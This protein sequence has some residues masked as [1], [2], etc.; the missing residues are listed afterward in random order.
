MAATAK[1]RPVSRRAAY[2]DQRNRR[3]RAAALGKLGKLTRII[4]AISCTTRRASGQGCE[5]LDLKILR[6]G[7]PYLKTICSCSFFN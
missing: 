7:S 3:L 5:Q 2:V 6:A 1:V 4:R